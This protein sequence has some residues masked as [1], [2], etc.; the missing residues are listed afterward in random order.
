MGPQMNYYFLEVTQDSK[1]PAFKKRIS[2]SLDQMFAIDLGY[3]SNS[4]LKF[5]DSFLR[6]A[7]KLKFL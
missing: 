6:H 4:R 1:T 7:T 2:Q 5:L 3:F